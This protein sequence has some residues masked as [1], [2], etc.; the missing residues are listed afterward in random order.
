LAFQ[1]ILFDRPAA[2][3]NEAPEAPEF[4]R[5]LNLDQIVGSITAGRDEY[6]L[7]PIFYRPLHDVATIRYR[8]EIFRDL[9]RAALARHVAAFA[10]SMR[11]VRERLAEA[12]KVHY[13]RQKQRCFLDAVAVYCEAVTS[14]A[15]HLAEADPRSRGLRDFRDFLEAYT[16]SVPFTALE[17]ETHALQASLSAIEYELTIDGSRVE[18][19]RYES[20]ADYGA[21]VLATFEKFKQGAVRGY[22]FKFYDSLDMN[23]VEAAILDR[24]ASIFPDAFSSLSEYRERHRNWLDPTIRSF[25]REVQFYIACLEH[26]ERFKPAALPFCYPEVVD[27]SKE[28]H[29]EEAFDLALADKL[30]RNNAQMITNEFHLAGPERILAVSGANQGGKT[31]FS[32]MF[33]QLHYLASL[34]CPVAAREAR[35]FLPD[36]LFTHFEREEEVENLSGKLEDELLRMR[37]ILREATPSSIII[38]NES[39]GSTTL[40]DALFLNKEILRLIIERDMLGVCVSF[41]DEL[42]SLGPQTV[43]MMSTVDPRDPAVRTFKVVRQPADGLAYAFAIAQKY[44]L[45]YQDLKERIPP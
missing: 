18:V 33:G 36:R 37:R 22:S 7:A 21:E 26:T 25:D 3:S 30:V 42:A 16:A 34:G 13:P 29:A 1:S 45:S 11:R 20:E 38:M 43:S 2:G 4:F 35:L 5:D 24:V 8:H 40:S 31:T 27:R 28:V 19:R 41:L 9:E 14:L 39:F 15:R 6:D 44:R 10:E 23:H 12:G 32:R 17:S